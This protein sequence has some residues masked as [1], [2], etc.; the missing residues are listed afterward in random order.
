MRSPASIALFAT[1][2]LASAGWAQDLDAR[3]TEGFADSSGVKI[4][5]ASLGTG[6]L[7]VMIHGFPDYW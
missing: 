2:T 3:V 6:P 5:Y 4:Q 7:V 1:G